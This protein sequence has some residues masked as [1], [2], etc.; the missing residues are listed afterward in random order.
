MLL[1]VKQDESANPPDVGF[2]GS[3]AV[4]KGLNSL[5]DLVE[6]A[7]LGLAR[8]RVGAFRHVD[9][10][11]QDSLPRILRV[12]RLSN[13]SSHRV[14]LPKA[15]LNNG[16]ALVLGLINGEHYFHPRVVARLSCVKMQVAWRDASQAQISKEPV[17]TSYVIDGGIL[18][19]IRD[20]CHSLEEDL[21][22]LSSAFRSQE[23]VPGPS[24]LLDFR[25]SRENRTREEIMGLAG[26]IRESRSLLGD[27]SAILVSNPLQYR[28]A[29]MLAVRAEAGGIKFSVFTD[30]VQAR[31]WLRPGD[32]QE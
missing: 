3:G 5:P 19:F 26:F 14:Y 31:R 32:H 25:A 10:G 9:E 30:L 24:L 18:H 28:L 16:R 6:K 17:P 29:R 15:A 13:A 1:A 27:R 23:L 8:L 2:F 22:A 11:G 21:A 12:S 4:L 7:R 20:G